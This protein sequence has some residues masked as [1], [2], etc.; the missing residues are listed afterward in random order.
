[1]SQSINSIHEEY[2][3]AIILAINEYKEKTLNTKEIQD[4]C[5]KRGISITWA[6]PADHCSNSG[7][8]SMCIHCKNHPEEAIFTK[9]KEDYYK[10][11]G[12]I[13]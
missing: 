7:S 11:N 2:H 9:I 4:I 1:M 5:E 13:P 6:S 8:M 10:V 12:F 3:M